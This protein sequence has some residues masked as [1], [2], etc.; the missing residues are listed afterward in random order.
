[1]ALSGGDQEQ[2]SSIATGR[3]GDSLLSEEFLR[4]TRGQRSDRLRSGSTGVDRPGCAGSALVDTVDTPVPSQRESLNV[5]RKML[6]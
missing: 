6:P 1:M 3:P 5:P 4:G 2:I